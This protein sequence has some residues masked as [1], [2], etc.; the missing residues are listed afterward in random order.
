[1]PAIR[2]NSLGDPRLEPYRHLKDTN[3]TRWAELFIC[4]GE[5]LVRRL[6]ASDFSIESVLISH[7]FEEQLGSLAAPD[8]PLLILPD[9]LVEPL[10]GFNFHRGIL[11]CGRRRPNLALDELAPQ[12]KRLTLVICPEVQDPENLGAI[13][14]ISAAF[15]VD[16]VL[17]GRGSADPFS[18][19]VLR[20]SMGASLRVPIRAA[21]D[22]AADI[23]HLR[24][25]LD[26]ELAAT[27]L[28][29]TAEP[30]STANRGDRFA[31]LFGS[32][33]HGLAPAIVALCRRRITIPMQRGTDSL[34][35][36]VAAGIFLHH[37]GGS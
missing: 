14:R 34:N 17:V 37:F 31:L 26:V 30:L 7:R 13:L 10:V 29:P 21:A 36:A 19:R 3:R 22:I 5:K 18:R 27:V 6:I 12:N 23:R 24:D 35:V 28:D 25:W 2:L 32:E 4:E 9:E 11:A 8:V 16:A 33:G 15:G 20:V 1:M